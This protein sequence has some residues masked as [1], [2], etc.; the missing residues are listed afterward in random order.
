MSNYVLVVD[1]NSSDLKLAK[2]LIESEGFVAILAT[3]AFAALEKINEYEFKLLVVDIQMPNVSGLE[4]LKRIKKIDAMKSVPVLIMSGRNTA[5]DIKKAVSLGA[6]DYI[7]K[8]IDREVFLAKLA[9][10]LKNRKTDWH[11]YPIYGEEKVASLQESCEI[12]TFNEISLT[13]KYQTPIEIG[14]SRMISGKLLDDMGIGANLGRCFECSKQPDGLFQI[15]MS[16]LG[17]KEE[18]RVKIRQY[19]RKIYSKVTKAS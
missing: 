9:I 3:D 6:V 2:L 16:L 15:K 10:H 5:E 11:D 14:E 17:L 19:C 4:L 8:P 1:D 12:V 7:I 18:D 13:L